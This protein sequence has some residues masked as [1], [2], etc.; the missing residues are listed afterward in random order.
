LSI[1]EGG[2]RERRASAT[3]FDRWLKQAYAEL[4][5]FTALVLLMKI[6]KRKVTPLSSTYL[7][8]IGDEVD[9]GEIVALFAG[10]GV[11]WDAAAFF[12]ITAKD[13]GPVDNATARLRLRMLETKVED[14]PLTLNEG[15]FFDSWGRRLRIDE[16]Q[17]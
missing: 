7:N 11:S 14:D 13:G 16:V 4:I 8:V 5:G 3:D 2:D 15:H 12:P 10:S 6:S 9:W 17:G 1:S